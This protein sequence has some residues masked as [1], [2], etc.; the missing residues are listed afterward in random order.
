LADPLGWAG[1]GQGGEGQRGD[2]AGADAD[3]DGGAQQS[4]QVGP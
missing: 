4:G 3:D 1:G 2:Q